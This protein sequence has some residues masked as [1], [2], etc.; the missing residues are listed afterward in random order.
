MSLW[1]S[2]KFLLTLGVI[3]TFY[4]ARWVIKPFSLHFGTKFTPCSLHLLVYR[5]ILTSLVTWVWHCGCD[6]RLLTSLSSWVWIFIKFMLFWWFLIVNSAGIIIKTEMLFT[7]G[8]LFHAQGQPEIRTLGHW[9]PA[10]DYCTLK[11]KIEWIIHSEEISLVE[12][13]ISLD[14][15]SSIHYSTSGISSGSLDIHSKRSDHWRHS[16]GS[17]VSD[18]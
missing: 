15:N 16:P 12:E 8:S 18:N 3:S 14:S 5:H 1:R 9:S 2:D 17:E 10:S 13:W 6:A 11:K 7:F 4:T